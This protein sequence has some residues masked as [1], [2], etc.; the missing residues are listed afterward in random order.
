MTTTGTISVD[1]TGNTGFGPLTSVNDGLGYPAGTVMHEIGH[2]LGLGHGGPYNG[3]SNSATDQYSQYDTGLYTIMSYI[4]PTDTTA[5]YL[6][7]Y[8]VTGTNWGG[9]QGPETPMSVDI[10]TLQ[11]LY[12]LPTSTPLS[13][14]QTFGY[15]SNI[16]GLLGSYFDFTKTTQPVLTLWD[17]G[18]NNT[19]NLSGYSTTS[20]VNL[21][22]GTFSS[23]NGLTNN[24]GIAFNTAINTAVGGA[25]D[26]TFTVNAA[27]DT[28]D[29]GAGANT[30]IF[31]GNRA[32]YAL[33]KTSGTVSV[34]KLSNNVLDTLMNVTTLTFADQSVQASSIAC[35]VH[36]TL[37][38]TASGEVAVEGLAIGDMVVTARGAMRPI[39][40]LGYRSYAGRFLQANAGVR[41]VRFAAG[42]LGGGLPRRDLLISP[43]HAMFLNGALFPARALING[44]SI[45]PD[46]TC[47]RVDYV[48]I[49][50]DSHDVILA[51]GAA[52]ETFI[53]DDSRATFNNAASYAALYGASDEDVWFCAPR[54][55]HGFALEEVLAALPKGRS[56]AA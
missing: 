54:V 6:S 28:I 24:I 47:E 23:T 8:S 37:I 30:I 42:S 48:H 4:S 49:E 17:A 52:S 19:L 46:L 16:T 21:N 7:S 26:D 33:S 43:E 12:G 15:S 56:I 40:W 11:N 45:A 13:G 34:N 27:A 20:T 14:N 32:D 2:A 25:G 18:A 44:S 55:E 22:A 38:E 10:L 41:P 5:K 9:Y 35:F 31:S 1:T 53:D 3:A 36:G 29:G 51:E 39:K 50:L